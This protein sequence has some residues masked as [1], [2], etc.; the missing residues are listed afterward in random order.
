MWSNTLGPTWSL[1]ES[2]VIAFD[3]KGN[4]ED[5]LTGLD[6]PQAC[7]SGIRLFPAFRRWRQDADEVKGILVDVQSSRTARAT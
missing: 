6:C 2:S 4:H 1:P 7:C 3:S 5:E